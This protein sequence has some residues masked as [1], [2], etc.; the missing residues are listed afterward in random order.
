K[1]IDWFF[2][3]HGYDAGQRASK[4]AA[5]VR[6][7]ELLGVVASD[8]LSELGEHLLARAGS[9]PED[10]LDELAR[11]CTALLPE[12]PCNV[13]LQSD[14]TAVISGQPSA[15]LSRLLNDAAVSETHGAARTW[16]FTPASVRAVLD[17]GWSADDL[18]AE[19]A[20]VTTRPVP[21]PLEYLIWDAARRHGEVRVRG[22]RSCVI[23]DEPLVTEMLHTRSLAKLHFSRLATTVLS[24]PSALDDVLARLRE[25]G[26]SPIAEDAQGVVIVEARHEHQAPMPNRA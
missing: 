9:G 15:A 12:S 4:V 10:G 2:P 26:L 11:R 5:A 17:A 20:A 8:A 7:A 16:R 25:A 14:L 22:M 18:L 19:L 13:I 24:S 23:A 1:E 21:Q 6:E 3:L